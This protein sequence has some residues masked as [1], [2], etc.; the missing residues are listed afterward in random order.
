MCSVA[1]KFDNKLRGHGQRY[2]EKC[3]CLVIL[4][5][6]LHAAQWLCMGNN[7]VSYGL[8][9]SFKSTCAVIL[10]DFLHKTLLSDC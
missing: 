10:V 9:M 3:T 7:L 1:S 8:E 6:Y 4:T 5:L 2:N